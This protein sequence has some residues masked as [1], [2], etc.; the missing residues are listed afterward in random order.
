MCPTVRR[1]IRAPGVF[2]R[3][4]AFQGLFN[5]QSR[6]GTSESSP[7]SVC[8]SPAPPGM[9][10]KFEG[11]VDLLG[12][13]KWGLP[14]PAIGT[15]RGGATSNRPE[16]ASSFQTS[17]VISEGPWSSLSAVSSTS[18]GAVQG[19]QS[20]R[21]VP[22]IC[23]VPLARVLAKFPAHPDRLL[24]ACVPLRRDG[25]RAGACGASAGGGSAGGRTA[26]QPN[27]HWLNPAIDLISPK[28]TEL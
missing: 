24:A 3:G 15:T 5:R 4:A 25:G 16:C 20:T 9:L 18:T 14:L 11:R 28:W 2:Q 7:A 12:S 27:D 26:S 22:H 1:F 10:R 13:W 21:G 19:R 23:L 17:P 6:H 8:P